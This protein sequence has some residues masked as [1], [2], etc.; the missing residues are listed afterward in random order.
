[1]S[2]HTKTNE[3]NLILMADDDEDDRMLA[4]DAMEAAGASYSCHTVADGQELLDYLR[5]EGQYRDKAPTDLP[6]VIL[7]DLN[8]PI[9]DGRQTLKQLKADTRLSSIP[10]VILSTSAE[11]DDIN[12]GYCL[13]ASSYMVKPT[14]F[15][16]MVNMMKQ[17]N[18]F[19]FECA[20][21][22]SFV[23]H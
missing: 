6:S 23:R 7:L 20:S 8:M 21:V 22:P 5:C 12:E 19:W 16:T 17:F 1:M 9:L 10:V 2:L 13:G 11:S 3:P 14:E 4:K 15:S 18:D